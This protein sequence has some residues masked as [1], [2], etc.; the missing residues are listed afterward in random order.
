MVKKK[1]R[2]LGSKRSDGRRSSLDKYDKK[3]DFAETP[4]PSG[5]S[6]KL[7]SGRGG[8]A[9]KSFVMQEHH[10][11]RMHFDLRL[12][13]DGVLKSWAVTRGP[14]ANPKTRR[15]AVRTEDHPV[16]YATFEGVIPKGNYGA[17][18]VMIWDRGV[19]S[20]ASGSD[21]LNAL[22][23]GHFKF[24]LHGARMNGGWALVRMPTAERGENWLLVK[25]KDE[26]AETDDSLVE[27]FRTSVASGAEFGQIESGAALANES[28]TASEDDGG[29]PPAFVKP[30]L[31]SNAKVVPHHGDWLFEMKYDG[32]RAQIARQDDTIAVYTRHGHDWAHKFPLIVAGS[33]GISEPHFHLDG[34]IVAFDANGI[35]DFSMLTSS[36]SA[37]QDGIL[38]FV[39]FDALAVGGRKLIDL[40]LNE[41]KALLATLLADVPPD[42]P[43]RLAPFVRSRGRELLKQ[44]VEAGGEGIIA[45]RAE[46]PYRSGRH[47]SWRKIKSVTREDF[48]VVG[49]MPSKKH[50]PF[51][52]LLAAEETNGEL[53]YVGRIGAGYD[54][55]AFKSVMKALRPLVQDRAPEQ[56]KDKS[57]APRGCQWLS[58]DLIAA[59]QY[60]SRTGDGLLRG[61]RFLGLRQ[62][63]GSTQSTRQQART[64]KRPFVAQAKSS[65][66]ETPTLTHP[67]RVVFPGEGITKQG[68]ADYYKLVAKKLLPHL[69]GR[70]VSL[71][72]APD[73]IDGEMFFQR[74]P[75]PAMKRGI[76]R[77]ADPAGRHRNYMAVENEAGLLT[78]VQF[79]AIELHGWGVRAQDLEHP[80]R[81]VFDLDPDEQLPFEDVVDAALMMR[82]ILRIA[83]LKSFAMVT[84][85]KGLHVVVPLGATQPWSVVEGFARGLAQ[86]LERLEPKRFV[87]SARKAKRE[88]RIFID[89]LRN[90]QGASAI[91]PYSLRAKSG[92]P[93]ACPVTWSELPKL[94]AADKFRLQQFKPSNRSPWPGFFQADQVIPQSAL[95]FMK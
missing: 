55:A 27:R 26:F 25:E 74:H 81:M 64:T 53:R 21:A 1:Q 14:S 66:P 71:V 49:Y 78:L 47:D 51:A 16:E 37:G 62:D 57:K 56:L 88:G 11:R 89:W 8:S 60:T 22:A 17:G 34:E 77:V 2:N 28:A 41:R 73:G 39:A 12:E 58:P 84:G 80:D 46:K 35:S 82:D 4:E 42:E 18:A 43:I 79:G 54:A 38:S 63:L 70:P 61:A 50:Q 90:K 92:A 40:Q 85:G 83:G 67:D 59:V 13:I 93:I 5:K 72:R 76:Q 9:S 10:A 87:A 86:Q 24:R 33:R 69:E 75:M 48:I 95:D 15:L 91:A 65:S 94:E 29:M 7:Y 6:A 32:Y 44:V 23:D 52:S 68:V 36:L 19:W 45:K 20:G 30:A 3:R 31:C